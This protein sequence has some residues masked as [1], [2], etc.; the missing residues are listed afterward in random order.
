MQKFP[1]TRVGYSKLLEELKQLKTQDRPNIIK[2]IAEAREQGDLSENA[3]Y[4]SAKEKQSFIEGRII[5]LE[6][7]ISRSEI[8]DTS[9][10][11]DKKV[12]FGAKVTLI[13]CD[14]ETQSKYQIVGEYE[15]DINKGLIAINSPLAKALIGKEPQNF[16]EVNTPTGIKE[17]ELIDVEYS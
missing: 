14:T 7:K 3:D 2:A 16:I 17:Y 11:T 12:K 6:D 1:I 15:S 13:N 10:E 5:D 9:K 8:L 4:Q